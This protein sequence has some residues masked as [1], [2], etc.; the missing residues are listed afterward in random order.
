M[1]K[2]PTPTPTDGIQSPIQR[3]DYFYVDTITFQ[4]ED[5]LFRVPK[6]GFQDPECDF[7]WMFDLPGP[8]PNGEHVEGTSD[9]APIILEGESK[10][11]FTALLKVLFY[12]LYKVIPEP[13]ELYDPDLDRE[14]DIGGYDEWVGVLHLA[15]KW[16]LKPIRKQAI[17]E[18]GRRF[19]G[20]MESW[21]RI[22]I[23]RKYNVREWLVKE[24]KDL[25][26]R[27]RPHDIDTLCENLGISEAHRVL[28]LRENSSRKPVDSYYRRES[29]DT[30]SDII[31]K[32]FAPEIDAVG[33]SKIHFRAFLKALYPPLYKFIPALGK[34]YDPNLDR[35]VDISGYDEWLGVL[36]LATK[37]N[38]TSMR[39]QAISEVERCFPATLTSWD[40]MAI[41]RKYNVREWLVWQY[42]NL[43]NQAAAHNVVT[44]F[45]NLS[46][47][48]AQRVLQLR[49]DA[50][51]GRIQCWDCG[52]STPRRGVLGR[53][54]IVEV[55]APEIN[56]VGTK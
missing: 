30:A 47:S 35:K 12:P 11:H 22:A 4:V 28:Q 18:V 13:G 9:D 14:V 44:L 31:L 52:M 8:G 1:E 7:P 46:I 43:V 27:N 23:A 15:T 37:W 49:E 34:P 40:K 42:D 45:E 51:C 39:K 19:P 29:F 24:Y 10:S 25:V 32:T 33:E 36:H 53:Q 6:W 55:F 17:Q 38:F 3:H 41:A 48:E 56:S 20:T 16:N 50:S 54:K 5:T 2:S 26:N 21:D